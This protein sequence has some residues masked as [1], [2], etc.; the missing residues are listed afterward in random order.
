MKLPGGINTNSIPVWFARVRGMF[1]ELEFVVLVLV[2]GVLL[3]A[4]SCLTFARA[5]PA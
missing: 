5:I 2:G 3:A 1:D 4:S